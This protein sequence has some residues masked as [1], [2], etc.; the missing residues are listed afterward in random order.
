MPGIDFIYQ[1]RKEFTGG[2]FLIKK[3]AIQFGAFIVYFFDYTIGCGW[4]LMLLYTLLM[5]AVLVVRGKP[6]T[7]EN[8]A[9]LLLKPESLQVK[10][11]FYFL[12][13]IQFLI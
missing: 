8:M 11:K 3:L 10:L 1:F 7:G 6:Y 5:M 9:A 2:N 13:L 4:W 12:N